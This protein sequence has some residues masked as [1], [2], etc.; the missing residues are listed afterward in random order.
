MGSG[1]YMDSSMGARVQAHS[2]KDLLAMSDPTRVREIYGRF[3]E[4]LLKVDKLQLKVG[5]IKVPVV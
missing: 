1:N 2:A 5:D 3:H 4:N